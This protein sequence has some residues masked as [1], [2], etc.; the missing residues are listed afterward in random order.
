MV[1]ELGMTVL[2]EGVESREQMDWLIGLGC[3]YLQGY[4]YSKPCPF[5]EFLPLLKKEF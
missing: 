1:K 5:N 3:D 2:A 4:Y